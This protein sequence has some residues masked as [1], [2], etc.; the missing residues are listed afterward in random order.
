MAL[1]G[2]TGNLPRFAKVNVSIIKNPPEASFF[3]EATHSI[4]N[5]SGSIAKAGLELVPRDYD[6]DTAYRFRRT[7]SINMI[8]VYKVA[9]TFHLK[10]FIRWPPTLFQTTIKTSLKGATPKSVLELM[11]V[12]YLT[13]AHVK[14][15]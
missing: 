9:L 6:M 3:D 4:H 1:N 13:L 11:N 5:L 15:H 10:P 7:D 2:A 14:H 8:H 12:N